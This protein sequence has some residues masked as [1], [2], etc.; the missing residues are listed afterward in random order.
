[1]ACWQAEAVPH[2][3][4]PELVVVPWEPVKSKLDL[5]ARTKQRLI[6]ESLRLGENDHLR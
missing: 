6:V 4:H 3:E 5:L 2:G 1:M